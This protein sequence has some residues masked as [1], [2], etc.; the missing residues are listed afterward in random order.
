[1]NIYDSAEVAVSLNL[2]DL[3]RL[4]ELFS[5]KVEDLKLDKIM[6]VMDTFHQSEAKKI[7]L[8]LF[9]KFQVN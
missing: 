3:S 6:E 8:N 4:Q 7:L 5:F 1:M 2:P 9:G